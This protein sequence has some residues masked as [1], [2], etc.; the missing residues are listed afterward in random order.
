MS[1]LKLDRWVFPLLLG[2][3]YMKG[4]GT[5]REGTNTDV[6]ISADHHEIIQDSIALFVFVCFFSV[7]A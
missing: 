4:C 3:Q 1:L 6:Y 2:N 7:I 5:S